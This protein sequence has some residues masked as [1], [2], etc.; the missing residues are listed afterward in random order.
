MRGYVAVLDGRVEGICGIIRERNAGKFF[1]DFSPRLKPYLRSVTI[2]RGVKDALRLCD[3]YRGPV[4]AV[5][6]HAEGCRLLARLGFAHL[7][8]AVYGW[9]K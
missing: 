7:H 9:L 2:M 6:E 8:G 5:A 4:M 1:A 3:E